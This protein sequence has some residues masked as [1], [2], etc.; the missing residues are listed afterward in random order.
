VSFILFAPYTESLFLLLSVA[1]LLMARRRQW[2]LAGLAGGLAALTRQQGL[3]LIVP[4]AWEVW[5]NSGRQWK[6]LL[7]NWRG[8]A[9]IAITLSGYVG[10]I[11]YR[12]VVVNDVIL[13][14]LNPQRI[15]YGLLLSP[16]ANKIVADQ[17]FVLPWEAL[18]L[19]ITHPS[20]ANILDLL[21]GGTYLLLLAV[22]GR[23][24]W[25]LRPSYFLSSIG[26]LMVGFLF[27]SGLADCYM[28]LPRHCILAFPSV[29]PLAYLVRRRFLYLLITAAGQCFMI[30]FSFFYFCHSVWVP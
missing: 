16:N 24:L 10:L 13:D 15:F 2:W 6:A 8:T 9:S 3:F 27:S 21:S 29:I 7:R 12:A 5:E 1:S 4:L 14:F 17:K 23:Q 11:F 18:W 25:P 19:A 26:L 28:G 30:A 20:S 22:V